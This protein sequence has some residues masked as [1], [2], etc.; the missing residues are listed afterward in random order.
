MNEVDWVSD[1]GFL[2][3]LSAHLRSHDVVGLPACDCPLVSVASVVASLDQY[4][5][6][7]AK[8]IEE[9]TAGCSDFAYEDAVS[10]AGVYP[11]FLAP[12]FSSSVMAS[13]SACNWSA[14]TLVTPYH[15]LRRLMTVM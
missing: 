13:S 4:H 10:F 7:E 2:H 3:R 5:V 1:S 9:F 12:S 15:S 6:L 11:F 14:S 8:V